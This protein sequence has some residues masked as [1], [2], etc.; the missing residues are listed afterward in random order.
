MALASDYLSVNQGPHNFAYSC[1]GLG[2]GYCRL[3]SKAWVGLRLSSWLR[4]NQSMLQ[5]LGGAGT[6][7]L[8]Q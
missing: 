3:S 2:F 8:R 7:W 1:A 5:S 4:L 6:G